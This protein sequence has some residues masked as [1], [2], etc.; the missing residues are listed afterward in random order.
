MFSLI[1]GALAEGTIESTVESTVES[2]AE[3]VAKA[4]KPFIRVEDPFRKL[5]EAG[6]PQYLVI[7]LLIV[8]AVFLLYM[9]NRKVKWTP[10]ML[11]HGAMA[12]ALSF[13]LSYIRIFR[14]GP[15]GGSVTPG[16]MLPVMLFSANYGLIPGLIVGLAYSILQIIQGSEAV[17][18]LGLLLDYFLAFSALGL[19]GIAKHIPQKWGLYVGM[20]VAL[21]GR[22]VSHT[23]SSMAV[24]KLN[25]GGS[26]AYN[27]GYMLPEI[28]FCMILGVLIGQQILNMMKRS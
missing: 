13:V 14:M 3:T 8:L 7:G 22:F 24:Y 9:A 19:A 23:A 27:A 25:L 18:F 1:A 17:G 21:V 4:A 15:G 12:L 6:W 26:I 5:R 28:I 20:L 10:K 16:S 11:A 2:A